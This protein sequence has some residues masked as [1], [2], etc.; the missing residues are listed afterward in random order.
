[1]SKFLIPNIIIT[2]DYDAMKQLFSG[3][4]FINSKKIKSTDGLFFL[5]TANNKY[6]TSFEYDLGY[7]T[8][9]TK[10]FNITFTDTDGNFEE[11]FLNKSFLDSYLHKVIKYS[12]FSNT[13]I[14]E[15]LTKT[16]ITQD[17]YIAFGIGEDI[18]N[19]SS[20]HVA[21]FN[22]AELQIDSQGRRVYTFKFVPSNDPIFR[23]KFLYDV[24]AVNP[25]LEF[26]FLNNLHYKLNCDIRTNSLATPSSNIRNLLQQY[27]KV[28]CNTDNV[29]VMLPDIDNYFKNKPEIRSPE[30]FIEAYTNILSLK[31]T[32]AVDNIQ[33][34]I[35]QTI[36]PPLNSTQNSTT[37]VTKEKGQ[38]NSIK[39]DLAFPSVL[40]N[41]PTPE[42]T[43]ISISTLQQ[44]KKTPKTQTE[45]EE[46]WREKL[47]ITPQNQVLISQQN[48]SSNK[49]I[50]PP[51]KILKQIPYYIIRFSEKER[52][53]SSLVPNIFDWH[54]CLN[55]LFQGIATCAGI[56]TT[57]ALC[58]FEETDIN[59][60]NL[61]YDNGIIPSKDKRCIVIG[62]RSVIDN[63]L[64]RNSIVFDKNMTIDSTI[65]FKPILDLENKDLKSKLLSNDYAKKVFE[66]VSRGKT[67]S[68]FSEQIILD[69]LALNEKSNLEFTKFLSNSNLLKISDTPIFMNNLKNSNIISININNIDS[70]FASLN[71]NV[72]T[73]FIDDLALKA[74]QNYEKSNIYK[75]TNKKYED[76]IK[77]IIE[78]FLAE[79]KIT[80]AP[81]YVNN[82][83]SFPTFNIVSPISLLRKVAQQNKRGSILVDHLYNTGSNRSEANQ[84]FF[85]LIARELISSNNNQNLIEDYDI[86]TE[87]NGLS[88]LIEAIFT[89]G[90]GASFLN[91]PA[92]TMSNK[93]G[94]PGEKNIKASMFQYLYKTT[95]PTITLKTLPFFHLSNFRTTAG[96]LCILLSKRTIS[97]ISPIN[98]QTQDIKNN[99][100]F[101]S[102]V[103]NII[104]AK[105]VI[106]PQDC[107]SEF[108]IQKLLLDT[109]Q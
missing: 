77:Q 96:K 94:L 72:K 7:N 103:Y 99:L 58:L 92:L 102:G 28:A 16:K 8:K 36:S 70:Y 100:D 109:L 38:K 26:S 25:D 66:L 76:F 56:A 97:S 9:N 107:Y 95:S 18:T 39:L 4:K 43:G 3:D 65:E 54:E 13:D 80:D 5:S 32:A 63:Y 84:L 83:A 64:Y 82:P 45:L 62:V 10:F 85:S 79:Q 12:D 20:P 50:T 34:D 69:E 37:D 27:F 101:F 17:Y 67:S 61:W 106:T 48:K 1:M 19:W 47:G 33:I 14:A 42:K 78:K 35:P 60:L 81:A 57:D 6:L 71:F 2:K 51:T 21:E 52:F 22:G 73:D 11:S 108:V 89:V 44:P 59:F 15:L 86:N 23:R 90:K 31:V 88:T 53:K 49:T 40:G 98:P 75:V 41:K 30:Q 46:E 104:G 87:I 29:L 68:A 105:H 91:P 93:N 74:K 24:R 55:A